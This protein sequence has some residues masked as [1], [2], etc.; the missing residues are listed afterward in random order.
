MNIIIRAPNW[1]GDAVMTLP[2]LD[3]FH[4]NFPDSHIWI[5]AKGWVKELFLNL[6]YIEGT[7]SVPDSVSLKNLLS[8][9]ASIKKY[10]FDTGLLFSNSFS[11][12][13]LFFAARIPNRWGYAK[14]GRKFLLT[15]TPSAI[16]NKSRSHHV[17][18]YLD[19]LKGLGLNTLSPELNFPVPANVV[20]KAKNLLQ[21]SGV[22][23]DHPIIVFNPGAAYG[24]SKQWPA[25]LFAQLGSMLQKALSAE[26]IIVGAR[27]E[28]EIGESIEN[29]MQNKPYLL[30]GKTNLMELA[31]ILKT[32][33]LVISN[34]SGP[35]HLANAVHTP[36]VALFGPT[37]PQVTGPLQ[38]PSVVIKKEVPCWPC[39]YRE[40]PLDHRCML[41]ITPE[42][43][44]NTCQEILK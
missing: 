17:Y 43:V 36:V 30:I 33:T 14:D 1:I 22:N 8:S 9:A 41:E 38:P 26:I 15:R 27:S 7:I 5:A 29:Q 37:N 39:K 21:A 2:A 40:C 18:Y 10:N 6:D 23:L 4:L 20:L 35:M 44:F 12:A 16:A 11:S 28:L 31:G 19:L 13:F 25:F 32:A 24:P 34:D 3:S 42:E